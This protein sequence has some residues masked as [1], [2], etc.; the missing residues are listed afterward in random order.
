M[1]WLGRDKGFQTRGKDIEEL[2]RTMN[3]RNYSN[4]VRTTRMLV[5]RWVRQSVNKRKGN[6]GW[7]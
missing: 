2:E 5:I 6:L 3:A 1:R 7:L 4:V